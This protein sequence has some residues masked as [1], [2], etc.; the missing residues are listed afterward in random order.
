VQLLANPGV[1]TSGPDL[2][3]VGATARGVSLTTVTGNVTLS[4][5]Q[6]YSGKHVTG[7]LTIRSTG[8][9]I[10]DCAID[11]GVDCGSGAGIDPYSPVIRYSTIGLPTGG[12]TNGSGIALYHGSYAIERCLIQG[13]ADGLRICGTSPASVAECYVRCWAVDAIDDHCDGLQDPCGHEGDLVVVRSLIDGAD[14]S[15]IGAGSQAALARSNDFGASNSTGRTFYED[16]FV[17]SQNF[18]IMLNDMDIMDAAACVA[19]VTGT[20]FGSCPGGF[21]THT[22]TSPGRV[23]WSGNTRFSD[24]ATVAF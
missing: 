20:I 7:F 3:K 13:Y 17:M 19:T 10:E 4:T 2:S 23:T 1:E 8:V 9:V 21:S 15:G 5:P 11:A 16:N 22:G 14:R 24:G 6:T 18:G 12:L